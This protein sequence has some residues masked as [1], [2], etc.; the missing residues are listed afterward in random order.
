MTDLERTINLSKGMA[1]AICMLIGT[2][3][4][5]LPGLVLS[6]GN[7]HEAIA[8][9]ILIAFI[10]IPRIEISSVLGLSFPSTAGLIGY[11]EE[12]A[13]TW[14]RYSASYLI[15]GSYLFGLPAIAFIGSEYMKEFF[16][17]SN[18]GGVLCTIFI[19]SLMFISNLSGIRILALIN[20]MALAILL[21]I[22]GLIT[23]FHLDFL[24]SGLS[25][26][27]NGLAEHEKMN[28]EVI[29]NTTTLLFWAF[30]GWENL[31]FSLGEIEEP[32]KNVP[33][34]YWLSFFVVTV[35]YIAVALISIGASTKG[36][37]IDGA[38]GLS[39]I[40]ILIPG[41]D[42]LLGLIVI[43]LIANACSW[44]FT[45]SRL[46]FASGR[47]GVFPEILG[48]L[49]KRNIPLFSLVALYLLSITII[50]LCYSFN[51]P[52][53]AM[54]MLVNQNFIFIFGFVIIAYWRTE[55][56]WRKWIFS[57]LSILSISFLISGFNW[58]IVYPVFLIIFGY[59]RFTS[60]KVV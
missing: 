20:Y 9:W 27:G 25:V 42:L 48:K 1:L 23:I 17:L 47:T 29:W 59:F 33:L 60:K 45:A 4:L 22:I 6:E 18:T 11:V 32:E 30:L 37:S 55:K 39:R 16:D 51:V 14:G 41:G 19:V 49:S 44:N 56:R 5:A 54:M 28:P 53:E 34:L 52:V 21:L 12:A 31:S 3:I 2:G 46:V 36:V 38:A 13:G 7:V 57:A 15:S 10:T 8:G 50:V 24:I 40:V 35:A 26:A 43:V 58:K